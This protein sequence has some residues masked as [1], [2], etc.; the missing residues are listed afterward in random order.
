MSADPGK[1]LARALQSLDFPDFSGAVS[2]K[3][4]AGRPWASGTFSGARYCLSL[5]LEGPGA[6]EAAAA[7]LAGIADHQ[8]ALDGNV[9]ADISCGECEHWEHSARLTLEALVVEAD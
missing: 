3:V 1:A 5:L 9:V 4:L 8:F 6:G 7:F 2:A